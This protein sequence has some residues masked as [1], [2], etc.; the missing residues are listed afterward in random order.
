MALFGGDKIEIQTKVLRG[1][2]LGLLGGLVAW[3]SSTPE[4]ATSFNF[5]ASKYPWL[6]PVASLLGFL[7][8]FTSVGERNA[9]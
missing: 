9:K 7:G 5:L 8:G 3:A 6:V 4:G 1:A 2:F